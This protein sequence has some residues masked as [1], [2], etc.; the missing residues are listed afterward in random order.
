MSV[1]YETS[2]PIRVEILSSHAAVVRHW[3]APGTWWSAAER[4][5]IVEE[6]RRAWD[7][8]ELPPWES[9]STVEGLVPE[10][11][12]LPAAA[13]DL[14]WRLT[15]HVATLTPSWHESYVP[16][17]LS[18]ERYVE[19]VGLVAQATLVDRFADG[20]GV[21]RVTLPDPVRGEP[22]RERPDG[23]RISSHWVPTAPFV[24]KLSSAEDGAGTSNVRKALSLVRAE[25]E[26]QF[27]LIEAHYVPGG[28]LASDLTQGQWSLG[29]A[30]IELLGART[31]AINE[32]FY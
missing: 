20:L 13:I 29:R 27:E 14:I 6:S 25:R 5:A 10:D 26:M 21:D 17:R 3:A 24:D 32:C 31:S 28:A 15:N 18:P 19:I 30:Q 22:T 12:A 16:D 11:H 9:P 4:L 23:A 8:P 7:G 1:I 2:L